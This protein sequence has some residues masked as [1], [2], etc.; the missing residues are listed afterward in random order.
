MTLCPMEL[1]L[2]GGGEKLQ[3]QHLRLQETGWVV[4]SLVC[5]RKGKALY[6]LH[7]PVEEEVTALAS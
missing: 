4:G 1:P 2:K 5:F 3:G 7:P 6:I